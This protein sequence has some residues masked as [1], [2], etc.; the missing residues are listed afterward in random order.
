VRAGGRG[1]NPLHAGVVGWR[2][3]EDG[4]TGRDPYHRSVRDAVIELKPGRDASLRRR[5]PWVFSGAIA[6][7]TGSPEPGHVVLVRGADGTPLGRAGY[8]PRSQIAARMW[9]FDADE[10]IDADAIA[11]RVRRAAAARADL[12][13]DSDAAR[14]V[15]AESDGV[16][17]LI[18]DRYGAHV[19]VQL[20]AWSAEAWRDV[21]VDALRALDGVESVYE[22]SDVDVRRKEGLESRTGPLTDVEPLEIV[23]IDEAGMRFGVDVRRGHKTGFYLDQR[24]SRRVVRDL[25][26]GRRVLNVCSYTG[27]F[28]I[29]AALG[30]ASEV[31]SIDS[32]Q[33]ALDGL[34]ANA[35]RNGVEPGTVIKAD[36][37]VE[38]RRMRDAN[39]RYDLVVLDPPKLAATAGQVQRASRAYKDLN[40]LACRLLAPE[41]RLVTFSCSAAMGDE[42]FAKVVAGAA[43]DAG[44][45]AQVIARLTQAPDHPVALAFPEAAYLKGLVC[46]VP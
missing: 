20:S 10:V 9:T 15:F 18:V 1:R 41:G 25:A 24:T 27:G 30:G 21:I 40:W 29:A 23:E 33:P 3:A 7:V 5:H 13:P 42:L 26:H 12:V 35:A 36:A 38:L 22:R 28:S 6:R 34:V 39:E 44:R 19:V 45:D 31:T 4:S 46:R 17:G 8:S 2:A 37:F 11:G 16:P 14:L 43:L 32:S